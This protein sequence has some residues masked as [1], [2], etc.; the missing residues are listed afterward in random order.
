MKKLI[1]CI[2]MALGLFSAGVAA[3]QL[4]GELGTVMQGQLVGGK[5]LE[6]ASVGGKNIGTKCM[7]TVFDGAA[8]RTFWVVSDPRS[9]MFKSVYVVKDKEDRYYL[10]NYKG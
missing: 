7:A 10:I 8:R 1:L 2:A 9:I 4:N 6:V 5:C 3:C